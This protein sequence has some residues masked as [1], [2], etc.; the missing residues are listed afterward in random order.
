MSVILNLKTLVTTVA[1]N[2][3]SSNTE[4]FRGLKGDT[5]DQGIQGI[6]GLKGNTGDQGIQGI[7]GATYNDTPIVNRLNTIENIIEW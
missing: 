3:L 1:N 4:I 5:G 6:Q 7:P 2:F